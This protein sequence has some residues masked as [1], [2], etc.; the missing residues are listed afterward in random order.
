MFEASDNIIGLLG[1]HTRRPMRR[2]RSRCEPDL[3]AVK[4]L[5]GLRPYSKTSARDK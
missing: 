2:Q 1:D 4:R 3:W 5:H